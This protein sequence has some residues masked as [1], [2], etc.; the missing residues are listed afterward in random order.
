MEVPAKAGAIGR[1]PASITFIHSGTLM[2]EVQVFPDS[3][4]ERPRVAVYLHIT[5]QCVGI[6]LQTKAGATAVKHPS[7]LL[8]GGG[9]YACHRAARWPTHRHRTKDLIAVVL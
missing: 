8:T 7:P 1:V 3:A 5:V 4:D 6:R 9:F 2:R